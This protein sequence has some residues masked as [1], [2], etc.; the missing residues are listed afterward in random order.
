MK[1]LHELGDELLRG[2]ATEAPILRGHN[3]MKPTIGRS[4]LSLPV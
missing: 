2:K 3:D 1:V 4:D